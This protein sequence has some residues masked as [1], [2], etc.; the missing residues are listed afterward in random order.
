MTLIYIITIAILVIFSVFGWGFAL[1][2][3]EEL[4]IEKAKHAITMRFWEAAIKKP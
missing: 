1:H 2:Y 3:S 4:K